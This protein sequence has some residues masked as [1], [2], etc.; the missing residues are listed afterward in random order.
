MFSLWAGQEG[1]AVGK[2]RRRAIQTAVKAELESDLARLIERSKNGDVDA[3]KALHGRYHD[4]LFTYAFFRL[5]DREEARDVAQDVFL[6]A[7]QRLPSFEYR[8]EGSF[9]AWLFRIAHNIVVGRIRKSHRH[10]VSVVEELPE[11]SIEFEGEA[12]SRRL[13]V[14]LLSRLPEAQREVV[15]LRFLAGMS[16]ADVAAAIDK[17]EGAVVQLQL[18]GIERLRK[19]MASA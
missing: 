10:P 9:P 11:E 19:E 7:W 8:H 14:D 6:A 17:S 2:L 4:R 16:L 12:V 5:G 3:F 18:R 15:T 13:V 1:R